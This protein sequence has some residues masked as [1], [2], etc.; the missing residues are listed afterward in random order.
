[1]GQSNWL[2]AKIKYNNNNNNNKNLGGTNTGIFSGSALKK[3]NC[4]L[5]LYFS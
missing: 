2:I 4:L 1:M 5:F 3:G